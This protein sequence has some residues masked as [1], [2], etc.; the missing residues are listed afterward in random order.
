MY[1]LQEYSTEAKMLLESNI[2]SSTPSDR[3]DRSLLE[4]GL[5]DARQDLS[6]GR[7]T[8]LIRPS[9]HHEHFVCGGND[10]VRA[11]YERERESGR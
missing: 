1:V 3:W 7:Q 9:V 5:R 6:S 11:V 4:N 8:A 10:A 2:H